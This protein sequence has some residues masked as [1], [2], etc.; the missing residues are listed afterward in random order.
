[1][2]AFVSGSKTPAI[3]RSGQTTGV[4]IG[5]P[6]DTAT[7]SVAL[8][9]VVGVVDP[10]TP[11]L[12]PAGPAATIK[13]NLV[14]PGDY[15]DCAQGTMFISCAEA[16]LYTVDGTPPSANLFGSSRPGTLVRTGKGTYQF[17]AITGSSGTRYYQFGGHSR[18]FDNT[19]VLNSPNLEQ[20]YLFAPNL[21]TGT[22]APYITFLT[23]NT[24]AVFVNNIPLSATNVSLVVDGPGGISISDIEYVSTTNSTMVSVAVPAGGPY[25]VRAVALLGQGSCFSQSPCFYVLRSGKTTGVFVS[26]TGGNASIALADVLGMVDPSTPSIGV[27]GTNVTIRI[28]LT[29]P[30]D[31]LDGLSAGQL[32]SSPAVPMYNFFGSSSSGTLASAGVG[33][34]LFT[35][36]LT[37]PT[38]R[39]VVYY[40]FGESAPS[41]GPS[42]PFLVWPNLIL[43]SPAQIQV[44][45]PP[46]N[47]PAVI[48][49][50]PA[51]GSTV[52]GVVTVAGWALD[53][54]TAVGTAISS[55]QISVDGHV[56][57]NATF[58]VSRPD[59]CVVYPGRPGCPNV[60]FVYQFNT[61]VL[62]PG[63]HTITATVADTDAT[64][65]TA[66]ASVTVAV[67]ATPP[68]VQIDSPS[69]GSV[70]S[71]RVV[72]SGWALDNT[73]VIGTAIGSVQVKV[74]GV[75]AG[76]ATYGIS[77]P[78]VC[79]V[80]PGRAGCPNVGFSY[81]L[82]L[83]PLSG[84]RHT[85]AVS[86]TDSD[87]IP[88]M[89]SS[90]VT[91]AV[92]DIPPSVYIESPSPGS[93]VSGNVTVNGW[94][95]DSTTAI[96]TAISSVQVS[97]DGHVVGNATY[98]VSRPDVSG[99]SRS[100]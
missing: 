48:I 31:F 23:T 18:V 95:L 89:G 45:G 51:A 34:Y 86:A 98:G 55:V 81:L 100:R 65:D 67:S 84:G 24:L 44:I 8:S 63:Q 50:S 73:S 4:Y 56:V 27:A 28:N 20:P 57:G 72:I 49:D 83:A 40:Q 10:S 70:L 93:V 7:V 87:G 25:R 60:G 42:S 5:P 47:P 62:G 61:A 54:T 15:L 2:V 21:E 46:S 69:A 91:I 85:I 12:A 9:D 75:A 11:S 76:T 96:G 37:L 26:S 53:N 74:D 32:W 64:P 30:G 88:D 3:L 17:T 66:T 80:Y 22:P 39:G 68:S 14:D 52:S 94:A 79:T 16:T 29:D 43:G 1:V 59:V 97:V 90:E 33:S 82:N 78:D 77:R 99:V 41:F 13:I 38:S 36:G 19:N 58:G 35:G 6:S 71:G 92:A